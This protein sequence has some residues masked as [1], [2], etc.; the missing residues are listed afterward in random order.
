MIALLSYS[1]S[2]CQNN[3]SLSSTGEQ[4]GKSDS[5]FISYDDIRVVNAKL[6]QLK[7]E[8]EI[9]DSLR[10]IIKNDDKIIKEYNNNIKSLN[11]N[12]NKV[13]KQ[14]NIIGL[15]GLVIIFSLI[16]IK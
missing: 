16:F 15:G 7:Y 1:T 6:I 3:V 13:I 10:V 9:N 11:T 2:W 4:C 14:R 5:V 12:I 8:K